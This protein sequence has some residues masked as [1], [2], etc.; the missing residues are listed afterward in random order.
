MEPDDKAFLE[1][2][3]NYKP[4]TAS[5]PVTSLRPLLGGET[6][7]E[8]RAKRQEEAYRASAEARAQASEARANAQLGLSFEAAE[9]ARQDQAM[10]MREEQR[11]IAEE[12]AKKKPATD[13]VRAMKI[14]SSL[15]A[16]KNIREMSNKFLTVGKTAGQVSELPFFGQNRADIEG[17]LDLVEGNLIQDQIA[18]L[19][20][21]NK[22][23]VGG[24][25]NTAEEA[26]R[27][28][29]SIA[30]LDPN[31]SKEQFLI[32]VDRAEKYLQAQLE[33]AGGV[34]Q[35]AAASTGGQAGATTFARS[36]P[37]QL[38]Q[39]DTDLAAERQLQQAWD[40]GATVDQM[41]ALNQQLGRGAFE[42]A[43]IQQMQSARTKGGPVRFYATPTGDPSVIQDV[44]ASPV[45]Q[46]AGGAAL[47]AANAVTLGM[48]DELAPV[49]GLSSE[50]VQAA[51]N[52]YRQE[53]P[54]A[55]FGGEVGGAVLGALPFVRGAQMVSGGAKLSP[56]I[57][58]AIYG[59]GYGAGESNENRLLGAALGGGAAVG[60][61]LLANRLLPTPEL[62][63][64]G[65]GPDMPPMGPTPPPAA[66]MTP[67]APPVAPVAP[68]MAPPVAA[69]VDPASTQAA[70]ELGTIIRNA[71]GKG[72]KAKAAQVQIA[73]MAA[74]NPEARAAAERLGIEVPADVFSD[75]AQ[76]RAAIGLTR[77]LAGS[78]AEAA[79]RNTVSSAVDQADNVMRAFDAQFVEGAVAPGAV[80]GRVRD[81]LTATRAALNKEAS[82]LYNQVDAAVPKQT[83]VQM[84]NLSATLDEIAGEVGE[85]GMTAQ[86]QRL[87][88]MLQSEDVTYGRLIREKN[89]I[90]KALKK[91][92]SPY[93]SMDEAT[94]KRLYAA[95][96]T[97]QLDNV[98]RIGG[99][100]L[101]S[102]LRGANLIYAKERA[103]GTRIVNA[104]GEDLLGGIARK[105]NAAIS[106]SAKGDPG[107]FTRLMKAVP[108]DLKKEVVATALAAATRSGRGAERGGFGFSE[109]A[110]LYPKLRAN[111]PVYKQIVDALG[112]Q[113]ASALRDLFQVSKRI[114]EA[115]ANV[116]TTGKANQALVNSLNVE[117]LMAK[118][119]DSTAAKR[120]VGAAVSLTGPFAPI[121]GAVMPDILDA[122]SKGNP[123]AVQ[124]AG[125]MFVSPEFQNLLIEVATK[126]E[127]SKKAI[128][129]V[130]N[131][132]R[133]REFAKRIGVD[134]K[135]GPNWLRSAIAVGAVG[136]VNP[137]EPTQPGPPEGAIIVGPKQ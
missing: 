26:R 122:M 88:K 34:P 65:I 92:E 13:P 50:Q 37:G 57:G 93:G 113:S 104:F 86:E 52:Y 105:M 68:A 35:Q 136:T 40:G 45:G 107:E 108:D 73:E 124:A 17:S 66:A 70:A 74:V 115:R 14:Q 85:T 23:G 69:A 8:A 134:S 48:I 49:I 42:A 130:A 7:E 129:R 41:V 38:V 103:L 19:A 11:K 36:Q 89:L 31:Q 116:L 22:G 79:W 47:G 62:P 28:A 128:N 111:P 12:E 114:T 53:A 2:Y 80:S 110:S 100:E 54:I 58:E 99:E 83:P 78:E 77:S 63:T 90:G 61:G 55:S 106:E 59:A 118:V 71:V 24:L 101:R 125:K 127:A 43:A 98:G 102:Q 18:V 81:S 16:L 9:R 132:P 15:D 82:D 76:V 120:T 131:S 97:D 94:L 33:L 21:L 87:A 117:S 51:K 112:P 6:P 60:G 5:V 10:Q 84:N 30:N 27:L 3:G 96:S 29:A 126:P 64:A 44:M 25:A 123:D 32:G 39:T 1:K 20:E 91:Q 67:E 133:F 137:N 121:A 135:D 72:S 56:L 119:M 95:L 109:F 46:A 75:N 4:V